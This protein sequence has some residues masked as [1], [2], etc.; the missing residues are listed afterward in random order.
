MRVFEE[1]TEGEEI[2]RKERLKTKWA[3]LEAVVGAED[4]LT[5]IAGRHRVA[6]REPPGGDGGQGNGRLHEPGVSASTSTPPCCGY[7]PSGSTRRTSGA[8]SR[9]VMTGAASDPVDWQPH[10]RNK[11]EARGIGE[12]VSAIPPTR[13]GWSW[14]ATCG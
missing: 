3:Q 13:Y 9:W 10:I 7:G 2:E 14:C 8:V 1:V 4:R 11:P 5:L 6:L 12:S